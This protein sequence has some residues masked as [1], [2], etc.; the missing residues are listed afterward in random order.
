MKRLVTTCCVVVGLLAAT[1]AMALDLHRHGTLPQGLRPVHMLSATS[2]LGCDNGVAFSSYY[3]AT[4]DRLGNL[5][6]FG[7]GSVLSAVSFEHYGWGLAGPYDYDI[8]IW[9][10]ASCTFVIAK[11]GLVAADAADNPA[12]EIVDLCS[13]GMY[14]SGD[15]L[16]MIDPNTCIPGGPAGT[17]C[18]PDLMFDNQSDVFCPVIINSA[19]SSP[20]CYDV[21]SFNGPFLLRIEINNCATPTNRESWGHLKSIYR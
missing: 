19:E 13:S 16:V 10:P 21:S 4:D 5:F 11:N 15:M 3:Q 8:E 1:S 18:Y 6:N 20:A 17:D 9:D 7:T 12:V 2:V 14:L